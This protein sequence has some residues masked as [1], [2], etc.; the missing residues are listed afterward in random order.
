MGPAKRAAARR[1]YD[2]DDGS[3]RGAGG[4]VATAPRVYDTPGV[5]CDSARVRVQ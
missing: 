2:V 4:R 5:W 1:V 3:V